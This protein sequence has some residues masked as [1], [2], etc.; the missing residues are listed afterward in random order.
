MRLIVNGE[1]YMHNGKGSLISLLDKLGA[2]GERVATMVNGEVVAKK[3]RRDVTL[4]EG[5]RVE[6]LTYAGGG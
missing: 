1:E 2:K 4:K 3:E 5:D 6:V